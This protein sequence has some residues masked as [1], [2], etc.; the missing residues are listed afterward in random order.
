[1]SPFSITR[2]RLIARGTRHEDAASTDDD[3]ALGGG[4]ALVS[5]WHWS[6]ERWPA[7][8]DVTTSAAAAER[9]P[10]YYR[11]LVGRRHGRRRRRKDAQ[12][13]DYVPVYDED[14]PSTEPPKVKPQQ[15]NASRKILYYRNPMGLP[16]TSR[17][18]RRIRWGWT[19]SPRTKATRP[20]T[21]R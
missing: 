10:L 4:T 6:S 19:T 14:G 8:A 18:Q 9:N 1:M 7:H 16:D 2:T 20:T 15:A 13:R 11:D 21:A 3:L 17:C 5:Y 12:G